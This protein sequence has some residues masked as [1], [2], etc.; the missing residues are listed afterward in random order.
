MACK[1][2]WKSVTSLAFASIK[3]WCKLNYE[4]SI[5]IDK[6]NH[7]IGSHNCITFVKCINSTIQS[8]S[9]ALRNHNSYT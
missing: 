4:L 1:K 5:F 7:K 8:N 6:N 2:L 3:R 9:V